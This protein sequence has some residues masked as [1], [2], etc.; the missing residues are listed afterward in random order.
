MFL[1]TWA[2]RPRVLL[3]SQAFCASSSADHPADVAWVGGLEGLLGLKQAVRVLMSVCLCDA[4]LSGLCAPDISPTPFAPRP[5]LLPV[6]GCTPALLFLVPRQQPWVPVS[7]ATDQLSGL[8]QV[9]LCVSE[10]HFPFCKKTAMLVGFSKQ[11]NEVR[12]A[13]CLAQGPSC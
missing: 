2:L 4:C 9:E 13:K 5:W 12:V 10:P 8:G 3:L 11:L 6:H 1:G 7:P